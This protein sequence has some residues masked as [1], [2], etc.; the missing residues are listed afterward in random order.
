MAKR[1][2]EALAAFGKQWAAAFAFRGQGDAITQGAAARSLQRTPALEPIVLVGLGIAPL[3]AVATGLRWA[4]ALAAGLLAVQVL[5]FLVLIGLRRWIIRP[6]APLFVVIVAAGWT[7]A[8][9]MICHAYLPDLAI[10][11]TLSCW[12]LPSLLPTVYLARLLFDGGAGENRNGG[13]R[14]WVLAIAGLAVVLCLLAGIR[15]SLGAGTLWQIPV[16]AKPMLTWALTSSG[17]C[18]VAA[19]LLLAAA[20]LLGSRW[21]EWKE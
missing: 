15:E 10:R 8:F 7:T 1:L 14:K 21:A 18:V 9:R 16:S 5:T 20:P 19:V 17:G 3:V 2:R 6:L 13:Y 11:D 4:L 12:L